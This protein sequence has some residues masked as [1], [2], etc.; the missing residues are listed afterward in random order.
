MKQKYQKQTMSCRI[1]ELLPCYYEE[2]TKTAEEILEDFWKQETMAL[3]PIVRHKKYM[4]YVFMEMNA[5]KQ[6]RAMDVLKQELLNR[7]TPFQFI[8]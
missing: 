5:I 6:K 7:Y 2:S 1:N 4:K 8:V 3:L